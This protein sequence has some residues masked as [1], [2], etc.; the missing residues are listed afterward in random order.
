MTQELSVW[1]LLAG[2]V[3][4]LWIFTYAVLLDD[5]ADAEKDSTGEGRHSEQPEHNDQQRTASEPGKAAA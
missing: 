5:H 3:G 4:L 1:V 2:F